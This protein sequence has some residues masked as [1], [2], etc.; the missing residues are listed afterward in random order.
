MIGKVLKFTN[1]GAI[2]EIAQASYLL[3]RGSFDGVDNINIGDF[4]EVGIGNKKTREVYLESRKPVLGDLKVYA[5]ADKVSFGYFLSTGLP[6]D[7]FVP[8]QFAFKNLKKGDK[9]A[10]LVKEDRE[11]RLFGTMKLSDELSHDHNYKENDEV[12]GMVYSIRRGVG[13]FVAIDKKYDA[14]LSEKDMNRAFET[15]DNIKARV[16][17]VLPDGKISLS[18]RNRS[19]LQIDPDSVI[20]MERLQKSGKLR[21]G[22]KSDPDA[23]YKEFGISKQAFKRAAGKLKKEGLIIIGD[24]EIKKIED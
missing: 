23:I 4:I 20:I 24:H 19:H 10:V 9:V 11:G 1:E 16:K 15:G 13:A 3:P 2:I 18:L 8:M 5:I 22:D 6:N 21:L 12:E 14:L 7:L 17:Y